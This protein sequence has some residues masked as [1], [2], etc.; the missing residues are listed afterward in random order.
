MKSSGL[1]FLALTL[2]ATLA[3]LDLSNA[4]TAPASPPATAQVSV[5][6]IDQP[7]ASDEIEMRLVKSFTDSAT[8]VPGV[9]V[10]GPAIHRC[11]TTDNAGLQ[12]PARYCFGAPAPE[13]IYD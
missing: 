8:A 12:G 1:A 7:M 11:V 10:N 9:A 4:H 2:V 6:R 5:V 13:I 3:A